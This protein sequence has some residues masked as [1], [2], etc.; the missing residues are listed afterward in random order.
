MQESFWPALRHSY[1][2]FLAKAVAVLGG[3]MLVVTGAF[4]SGQ[5]FQI[6][7]FADEIEQ[8]HPFVRRFVKAQILSRLTVQ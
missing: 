1:E 5:V 4:A 6:A 3:D 8:Q 2:L 7:T